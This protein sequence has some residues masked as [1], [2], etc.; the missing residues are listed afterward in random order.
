M[1]H[2]RFC[3]SIMILILFVACKSNHKMEENKENI[4]SLTQKKKLENIEV[5]SLKGIEKSK[6]E[7]FLFKFS[8]CI[9]NCET[10][11]II[12]RKFN[13]DTLLLK[14]GSIQNCVENFNVDYKIKNDILDIRIDTKVIMLDKKEDYLIFEDGKIDTQ[15]VYT[16]CECYYYF[17]IGIKHIDKKYKSILVNGR[18]LNRTMMGDE[19]PFP[20]D[21]LLINE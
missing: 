14:F 5:D 12:S 10:E 17:E 3:L 8:E 11:K 18:K 6:P 19:Y 9:K 7:I 13:G 15:F 1:I 20:G 16:L 21:A 2:F 4:D